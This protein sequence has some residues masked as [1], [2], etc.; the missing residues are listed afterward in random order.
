[1][2][3]NL[4]VTLAVVTGLAFSLSACRLGSDIDTLWE[5]AIEKNNGDSNQ[6]TPVPD[7][8]E[9]WYSKAIALTENTWAD[10][11]N[12][13]TSYGWQGQVFS[14]I[15][16]TYTQYIHV[17]FVTA[18]YLE[19]DVLSS[20]NNYV[21]SDYFSSEYRSTA[22]TVTPGQKYYIR[23]YNPDNGTYRIAFNTSVIPPDVTPTQLTEN[24]WANGNLSTN[25]EQW[26]SFTATEYEQYIH[27]SF[28][29]LSDL[30][31]E[32]FSSSDTYFGSQTNLYGSTCYTSVPVTQ[33]QT[34][35]IKVTPYSDYSGT[36]KIAFNTSGTAP[37]P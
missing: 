30:Y 29:T 16:K 27:V 11:S 8:T 10:G 3:K 2:R 36:Y 1:M 22:L 4:I 26:Y 24:I 7:Y 32:V 15:A 23:V 13:T 28:G 19:V 31:V 21:G 34:Y 20:N 12:I 5:K 9:E 35:Y 25:G 6:A 18:N 33:G 37:S 17:S 14:F